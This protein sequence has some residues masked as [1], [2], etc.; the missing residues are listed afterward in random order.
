MAAQFQ[1]GAAFG[2]VDRALGFETFFNQHPTVTYLGGRMLS[3]IFAAATVF[4]TYAI[5]RRIFSR[6]TALAAAAFIAV[7]PLHVTYSRII[8]T[9]ILV[10]LLALVVFWFCLD[11][12]ESRRSR[13]YFLAGLFTGIGVATKYPMVIV[14]VTV[15]AAHLLGPPG[16]LRQATKLLVYGGGVL[17]GAFVASP[18]MF[19]DYRYALADVL[20]E[21]D[22]DPATTM[23]W[24]SEQG[25]VQ[26]LIWYLRVPLV[27]ALSGL[28]LALAGVGPPPLPGVPPQGEAPPHHLSG[29]PPRFGRLVWTAMGPLADPGPPLPLHHGLARG[30]PHRGLDR[31]A[32]ERA[33]GRTRGRHA[34][35]RRL[36]AAPRARSRGIAPPRPS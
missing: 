33:R 20:F 24:P 18:Y 1:I 12:L 31:R 5:A 6:S 34:G 9:D 35:A 16:R 27:D 26:D 3:L 29:V 14:S 13:S 32:R 28:G 19:L 4:L 11:I 7:S 36:G 25:L 8:R 10:G 23:L 15:L 21:A 17:L 22:P 30:R 2:L